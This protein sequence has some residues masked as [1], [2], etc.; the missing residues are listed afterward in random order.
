MKKPV[1]PPVVEPVAKKQVGRFNMKP[2]VEDKA[3][4]TQKDENTQ[5]NEGTQTPLNDKVSHVCK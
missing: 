4:N 5:T 2:V 3:K 1:P